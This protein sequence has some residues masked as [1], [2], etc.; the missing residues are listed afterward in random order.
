[1][2][3][4]LLMALATALVLAPGAA[5]LGARMGSGRFR[6]GLLLPVG[7]GMAVAGAV[8]AI[9]WK[10]VGFGMTSDTELLNGQVTGKE[11]VRVSCSHS[12]SCNC[13]QTTSCS[14][15]GANRSCSTTTSCDTC[16]EHSNDYDWMLRTSVRSI[17]VDRVDRQGVHT[18]PRFTKAAP[19]DPV[20]VTHRFTNY[21]MAA[22]H[23]LFNA[24]REAHAGQD[25]AVPPYPL[26]VYDLHY[27]DRAI[28]VG[29]SVPDIREW[30]RLIA[31]A[32]R[33]LGPSKQVNIVVVLTAVPDR[34]YAEHLRAA[35]LGGKKNDVVVVLGAPEY[36]KVQWA[37]VL[38]WTTREDMKVALRDE[39][40]ALPELS[41]GPAVTLIASRIASE[42]ER[43][44]MRDFEYL[45]D[46]IEPS[47]LAVLVL[48]AL[49]LAAAWGTAFIIN[50]RY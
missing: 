4:M 40:Q 38:S 15:S 28:P 22:Q 41:P 31:L 21:V 47:T 18:P 7:A 33:E 44:R 50:R 10:L 42:F 14:G 23:S 9:G 45:A 35:W 32:L 24:Q 25:W 30:N 43:R 1:M 49:S 48:I 6:R 34:R 13:R 17:E 16:Y 29:V 12:Y 11:Q 8:F 46:E 3:K 37:E 36:P 26:A 27:V 5:Y 20:A 2:I 19:G 39:L